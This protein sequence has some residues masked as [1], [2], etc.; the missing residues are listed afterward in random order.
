VKTGFAVWHDLHAGSL[1][2]CNDMVAL[3]FSA[4]GSHDRRLCKNPE[5]WPNPGIFCRRGAEAQRM[6]RE[7]SSETEHGKRSAKSLCLCVFGVIFFTLLT[8]ILAQSPRPGANS[9]SWTSASGS[10]A[11]CPASSSRRQRRPKTRHPRLSRPEHR[12]RCRHV[13]RSARRQEAR[14]YA[15]LLRLR[16]SSNLP[17]LGSSL[18]PRNAPTGL[19]R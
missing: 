4:D 16:T 17:W 1:N 12:G 6:R 5:N 18:F 9:S 15:T 19:G 14:P 10:A 3:D 2:I 13:R 8:R 7:K 11:A